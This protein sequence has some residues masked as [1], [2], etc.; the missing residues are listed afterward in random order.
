[1]TDFQAL[2]HK[3][4]KNS[5]FLVEAVIVDSQ[6]NINQVHVSD[7]LQEYHQKMLNSTI[8]PDVYQQNSTSLRHEQ[9]N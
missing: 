4:G 9:I 1:M 7:N 3:N 6:I 2:I 5:G 8:D